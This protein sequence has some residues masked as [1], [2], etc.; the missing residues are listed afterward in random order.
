MHRRRNT[1]QRATDDDESVTRE[2]ADTSYGQQL[3]SC[4]QQLGVRLREAEEKIASQVTQA[5]AEVDRAALQ[6]AVHGALVELARAVLADVEELSEGHRRTAK[7][8]LSSWSSVFEM[9]LAT[10]RT[11]A[12]VK[13]E[14]AAVEAEATMHRKIEESVKA[15]AGRAGEALEESHRRFEELSAEMGALKLKAS[16]VEEAFSMTKGLL[17]KSEAAQAEWLQRAEAAE[18]DAAEQ[19]AQVIHHLREVS[20][21]FIKMNEPPKE[22]HWGRPPACL[23]A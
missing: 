15:N 7:E 4:Q 3:E 22:P 12:A 11:A 17:R 13:L 19:R 6:G 23:T 21:F 1:L 2:A 5:P 16:G 14:A 8:T 20:R 18:A 10:S 9:K